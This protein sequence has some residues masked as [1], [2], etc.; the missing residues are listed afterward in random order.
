MKIT[1]NQLRRIIKEEVIRLLEQGTESPQLTVKFVEQTNAYDQTE[2]IF[3]VNGKE[4]EV[5]S[6]G[7]PS[8]D[9]L[10]ED[11]VFR[12]GENQDP[13]VDETPAFEGLVNHVKQ[14]LTV[15]T[16]FDEALEDAGAAVDEYAES[17][18]AEEW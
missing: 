3:S 10:A 14:Q 9:S 12:W 5:T 18:Y 11:I 4:V 6:S 8:S 1:K 13:P 17:Q 15:S 7:T 16:K 2:W